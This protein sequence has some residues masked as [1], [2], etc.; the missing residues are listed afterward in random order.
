MRFRT[1]RRGKYAGEGF[2]GCLRYPQCFGTAKPT[3]ANMAA[4]LAEAKDIRERYPAMIR[5]EL[6][7][8]S[9]TPHPDE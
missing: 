3:E 2:W 5:P 7:Q 6:L 8:E 9:V 4:Y 1:A